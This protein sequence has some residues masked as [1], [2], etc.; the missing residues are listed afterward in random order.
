M[1]IAIY[2]GAFNPVHK[3]HTEIVKQIS[4]NYDFDKILIIPSKFSPHK[5]NK[6]LVSDEHRLNMCKLTFNDFDKC[7][8]SDIEIKR[9]KI[10]FT[11][12]T[13]TELK[14]VYPFDEFYLVCGSDMFLSLLKWR[15]PEEIFK[16][17]SILA[18]RRDDESM[19][20]MNE[21]KDV[22]TAMGVNVLI[23]EMK[24]PPFSST[25]IREAVK[26]N[27]PYDKYVTEKV[28]D[29]ILKNKLYR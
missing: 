17:T 1:K 18:F 3:G 28:Y 14:T 8:V 6:E 5:S 26:S 11:V 22:L 15:N 12:D 21:Y 13:L 16:M 25:Q 4:E 7:E 2:G 9:N 23:C 20:A 29:Y 27:K 10:S 24:I 19:Q